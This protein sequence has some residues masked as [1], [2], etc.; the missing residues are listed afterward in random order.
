MELA[1]AAKRTA[2]SCSKSRSLGKDGLRR[3]VLG[4]PRPKLSPLGLSD[5]IKSESKKLDFGPSITYVREEMF[6]M[7]LLVE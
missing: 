2:V 4:P 3:N 5:L 1:A 6:K 7:A